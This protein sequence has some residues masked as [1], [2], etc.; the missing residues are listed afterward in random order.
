MPQVR[1][2][3]T[4]STPARREPSSEAKELREDYMEELGQLASEASWIQ[5]RIGRARTPPSGE[6]I[7]RHIT[8]WRKETKQLIDDYVEGLVQ[9]FP[10]D[11]EKV[12]REA[13]ILWPPFNEKA[14]SWV[15]EATLE[16]WQRMALH[17]ARR[18]KESKP[19]G[20]VH[21]E[22]CSKHIGELMQKHPGWSNGNIIGKYVGEGDGTPP[23][24]WRKHNHREGDMLDAFACP[25]CKHA[26]QSFLSRLRHKLGLPARR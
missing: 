22:E 20:G 9:I 1:K 7:N 3:Q 8:R 21:R 11:F 10:G 23:V 15:S 4:K 14:K 26:I 2:L 12:Q 24:R 17:G 6:E 18:R 16:R 19:R 5:E 13:E 25:D